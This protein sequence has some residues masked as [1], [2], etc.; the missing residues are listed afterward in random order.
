MHASIAALNDGAHVV[1]FYSDDAALVD[2]VARMV[3]TALVVGESAVV[4][5]TRPHETAVRARLAG[6]G[7]DLGIAL[8]TGRYVPLDAA[9]I[10]ARFF[11]GGRL[12]TEGIRAVLAD[13]IVHAG[14]ACESE[15]PRVVV[16]GE[17]VDLLVR[18]G[19]V[20]AALALERVGNELVEQHPI[21]VCCAYHMTSF[22]GDAGAAPF[23]HVC[24]QHRQVFPA[25]RRVA[26]TRVR[27]SAPAARR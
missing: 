13:T 24:G 2:V 10:A 20:A 8:G 4:I 17:I 23:L 26:R 15:V 16:F 21:A 18:G 7:L 27:R 9:A 12:D 14:A 19:S 11:V 22:R 3:G 6:R 5:A 25:E 1:Q